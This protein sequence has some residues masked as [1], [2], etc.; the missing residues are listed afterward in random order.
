MTSI[1]PSLWWR[2]LKLLQM[3]ALIVQLYRSSRFVGLWMVGRSEPIL[4]IEYQTDVL[5]NLYSK[6]ITVVEDRLCWRPVVE[7]LFVYS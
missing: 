7:C 4:N 6:A 2:P 3:T 5:V 1:G